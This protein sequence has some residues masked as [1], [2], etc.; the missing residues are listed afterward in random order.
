MECLLKMYTHCRKDTEP[1]NKIYDIYKIIFNSVY[2]TVLH[3]VCPRG[4]RY[5]NNA[6]ILK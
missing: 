4:R 2:I 6:P 3:S 5:M 1:T